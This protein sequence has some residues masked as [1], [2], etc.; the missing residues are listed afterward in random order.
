MRCACAA[1]HSSRRSPLCRSWYGPPR[2]RR[3][4]TRIDVAREIDRGEDRIVDLVE[5]GRE[6]VE[7]GCSGI[8]VLARD[9]RQ[10]RFALRRRGARV[11]DGLR[12][13]FALVNGPRPGDE[14]GELQA[15]ELD[16]AEVSLVDA[17]AHRCAAMALRGQRVE[18]AR[19]TDVAVA[20]GQRNALVLQSTPVMSFSAMGSRRAARAGRR[21]KG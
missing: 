10:Y 11:D 12:F 14:H 20:R 18:L 8:G 9:D 3:R 2:S 4:C 1:L 21:E 6:H 16:V 13:A 15:V 17:C 7:D 5:R 19:T